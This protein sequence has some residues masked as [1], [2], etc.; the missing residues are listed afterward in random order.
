MAEV[1]RLMLIDDDDND[2]ELFLRAIETLG[3]EISVATAHD[4]V[5]ALEYLERQPAEAL[6]RLLVIDY[7][8]PRMDGLH[9]LQK[10]QNHP[11]YNRI[12]KV[13]LTSSQDTEDLASAYSAGVNAYVLKPVDFAR[14]KKDVGVMMEFWLGMNL[15]GRNEEIIE[16]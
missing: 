11:R 2:I 1:K 15:V 16:P 12:P 14:F 3:L 13:V 6:P 9:L 4:G 8:M 5:E 7:K 10:L